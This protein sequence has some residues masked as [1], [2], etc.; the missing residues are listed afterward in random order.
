MRIL[1]LFTLAAATFGASALAAPGGA[2]FPAPNRPIAEIVSPTWSS[3]DRDAADESGQLV[4]LMGVRPGMAVADIGAGSGYHT[5]RLSPVVGP[6]G[7][8]YAQDVT[9]SYLEG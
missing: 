2:T 7:R 5:L 6:T 8:V 3:G 4:R 1:A 9:A